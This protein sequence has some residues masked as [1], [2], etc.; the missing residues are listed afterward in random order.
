MKFT[1]FVLI[2]LILSIGI[3]PIIPYG[4]AA[5]HNQICINKVWIENSKGKIACVT[6]STG[7]KLVERGWGTLLE[8]I[9]MAEQSTE[10]KLATSLEFLFVQMAT[11]GTFTET[12]DEKYSL[13]FEGINPLTI[14]FTDRPNRIAGHM[15]T[16]EFVH[17]WNV[18]QDS[19]ESNPPNAIITIVEPDGTQNAITVA[20]TNP[21]Y[22]LESIT[23]QY[24]AYIIKDE[25]DTSEQVDV[26][27]PETFGDVSLFI[28][29]TK[30]IFLLVVNH[31]D[32][33]DGDD[34]NDN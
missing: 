21:V 11:S 16:E 14:Y 18:G 20:L 22:D 32:N 31:D 9:S 4:D 23:L 34:D 3:M 24:T 12:D 6:P 15:S 10:E 25:V 1:I 7:D 8:D 27:F 5:E 13:T 30:G 17:A 29:P 19:F 33:D 2:S 28:D 26:Q